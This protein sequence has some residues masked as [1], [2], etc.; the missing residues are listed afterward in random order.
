MK[1]I[2]PIIIISSIS[3]I[4]KLLESVAVAHP[5]HTPVRLVRYVF[6]VMEPR[7]SQSP[8]ST[9]DSPDVV[10]V[11]SDCRRIGFNGAH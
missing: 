2:I 11:M 10:I 8:A 9:P 1:I 7:G 5:V 4:V 6:S 3:S